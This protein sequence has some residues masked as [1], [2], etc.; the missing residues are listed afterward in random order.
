MSAIVS[1]KRSFFEELSSTPPAS[2]RIRCSSRFTSSFSPSSSPPSPPSFLIDQLISIFPHMD[3]QVLER[4]LE[5]CG[6]DLD[7]AIRSLN[8]LCLGSADR[9]AAAADKTGVELEGNVQI[10]TQCI[11]AN[12]DVPT[13]EQTSPE[14]FSMDGS[15][16]VEL[17]VREMLNASNIDDAR[18]RASRAL[19]VFEKSIHARAGAEV[20]QN[21]HQENMMLKEQL[22]TLIQENTI[23]KRA[24]AVQHERQKEYENQSQ[25][26]QHLKQVISQYQEQLRTLE[27]NNYALTMH[28]KQAQQSSNIPGRFNP[29]VF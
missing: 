4:A 3:K 18:A 13:K 9:N 12:G 17:F 21:V 5:E 23:L 7:S 24:V 25:E 22:E 2:K 26:L 27:I 15:D 28:L 20:A 8:E 11:T 6:D 29:D 14:A 16:W 1:G 10:Q 19:E